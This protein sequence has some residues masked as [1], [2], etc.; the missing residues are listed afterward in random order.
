M[1]KHKHIFQIIVEQD[2]AGSYVAECPCA[3]GLLHARQNVR[4][5]DREHQG[6]DRHVPARPQGQ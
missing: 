4:G 6:C 1:A 2:E 5:S 3:A